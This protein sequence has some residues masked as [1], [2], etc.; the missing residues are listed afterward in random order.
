MEAGC[1]D[2]RSERREMAAGERTGKAGRPLLT[3]NREPE[4]L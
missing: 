2:L 4:I 3:W 1:E